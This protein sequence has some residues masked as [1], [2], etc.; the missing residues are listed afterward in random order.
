MIWLE[1]PH[2]TIGEVTHKWLVSTIFERRQD[3]TVNSKCHFIA[4]SHSRHTYFEYKNHKVEKYFFI[5]N[6]RT[7]DWP[8]KND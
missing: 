3:I 7:L 1:Y 5:N 8:G 6:V 2:E 4:D